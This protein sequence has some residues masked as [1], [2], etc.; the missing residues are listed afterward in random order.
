ML[1][2]AE[3]RRRLPI[4]YP[5]L[6]VD[7]VLEIEPE[8]ASGQK[9]VT[10]NEPYF[11]GHFPIAPVMPGVLVMESMF[12]LLWLAWGGH[13]GFHLCG[14][15]RLK[16]RRSVV[17]GDVLEL[18]AQKLGEDEGKLRF[19]CYARVDG[20]VAVEGELVVRPREAEPS[21][22]SSG[23]QRETAHA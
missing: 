2:G 21:D 8:R 11:R 23:N 6:L 5:L 17:P 18:E 10:A 1:E 19:R 9:F 20:K 22:Q 14:V 3:I 4:R 12:Q 16:F 15:R 7:R 13:N